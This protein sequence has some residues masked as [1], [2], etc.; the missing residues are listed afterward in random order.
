MLLLGEKPTAGQMAWVIV[1]MVGV[2]IYFYPVDLMWAQILGLLVVMLGVMANALSSIMGR[3]INRE[4]LAHPVVVTTV[5]MT[6]GAV[7]LLS[8]GLYAEGPPTLSSTSILYTVWLS[9]VNTALAFTIWNRAMRTLRAVDMTMI[10]STMLPQ[11]AILSLVFLE[12][13]LEYIDWLGLVLVTVSVLFIQVSQS[14]VVGQRNS[15]SPT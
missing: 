8:L 12:M 1:G 6:A 14:R 5:S 15:P 7:I 13:T 11:I 2:V 9:A 10:N 4:R 3:A